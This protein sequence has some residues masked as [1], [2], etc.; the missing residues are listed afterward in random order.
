MSARDSQSRSFG[1]IWG[2]ALGV[3][4]IALTTMKTASA[5]SMGAMPSLHFAG[6]MAIGPFAAC[7]HSGKI[8]PAI[9]FAAL[10][11]MLISAHFIH[12][13]KWTFLLTCI[14]IVVWVG[15]G[16]MIVLMLA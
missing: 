10:P 5:F 12:P 7:L 16:A 8:A 2:S 13:S 3:C 1:V 11:V 6:A 4:L 14:G 15:W 9:A